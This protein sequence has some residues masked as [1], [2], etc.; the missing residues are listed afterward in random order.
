MKM[1]FL[2][3]ILVTGFLFSIN[4]SFAQVS[5][6]TDPL[7]ANYDPSAIINDGSCIYNAAAI[8]PTS[9]TDLNS[10]ISETSGLIVWNNQIWTLNDNTD[11]NLYA[12][13]TADGNLIQPYPLTGTLNRD[14]EEISQDDSYIYVG[15]L[16]NNENGNRTDLKILRITKSS[17]H[18]GPVKIDT[19]NF[20]Y[21]DQ[22]NFNPTGP[23]NTDFDCEAFIVSSD[24]IYLFTKQ[25]VSNRT[26]VYSLPKIPGTYTANLKSSYDV[27]GL[28]TG[29]VFIENQKLIALC[30]YSNLLEP[31]VYLLYDFRGSEYFG[32]NKR[33]ITISL[34]FHQVE[35]I[36]TADGLKYFIS[37][38]SFTLPPIISI[39]QK[40]HI[41]FLNSFLEEYLK[42]PSTEINETESAGDY[43]VYPV[44]AE[45]FIIVK[46]NNSFTHADYSLINFFGQT[47]LNGRLPEKENFIDISLLPRG[48]YILQIGENR[49]HQFKVI[50][51]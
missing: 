2:Y 21:S 34:P 12:L 27:K 20:L 13:D 8:T 35:G 45:N 11:I 3:L 18:P 40:L 17:L 42:S 7:A 51:R 19:I 22:I 4:D 46:V 47:M 38:E 50:R 23:E 5:G 14:W 28:I 15:D 9:G 32:G 49:K 41:F 33:K 44:P 43:K 30:G 31:F 48:L 37:N 6:C 26:S 36:A 16:G 24:S 10:N 25:W 1:V 39:P 29:A